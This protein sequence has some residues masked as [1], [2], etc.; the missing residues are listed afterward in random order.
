MSEVETLKKEISALSLLVGDIFNVVA[1]MPSSKHF[2]ILHKA[3]EAYVQR[4]E[5]GQ[6]KDNGPLY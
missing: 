1:E 4:L 3:T 5:G 2:Y 6:E